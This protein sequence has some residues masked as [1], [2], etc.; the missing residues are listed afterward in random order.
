[1]EAF[2]RRPRKPFLGLAGA[3]CLGICVAEWIQPAVLLLLIAGVGAG[4][5]A[6]ARPRAVLCWVAV[7]ATFALLHTTRHLENAG[8]QFAARLSTPI[9]ADVEGVVWSEPA[10]FEGSRGMPGATFWL[11]L[12]R[13]DPAPELP[14][15]LCLARWQG[16]APAYGDRVRMRGA[17]EAL[18]RPRN[19]GQFDVGRW[20][21]RQGVHF[22]LAAQA[23]RDCEIAG[24][25]EGSKLRHV[26]VRARSWIQAQLDRGLPADPEVSALI[27]SMVLGLRGE[28]PAELKEL[29]QKT[30][31]LHLFAVSGLN[32]GMLAII[33][34]YALKPLGFGRRSGALIV[35]PLL[36]AYAVI[37]GMSASCMRATVVAAFLLAAPLWEREAVPVNSLAAAAVAILAWDTNEL[38]NP[39]FQLSFV[40]VAVI[41]AFSLRWQKS[42]QKI[43]EPDD[44]LPHRLWNPWQRSR[45]ALGRVVAGMAAV[46]VASWLGSVLFMWG[47]F[48]L[49][50]P[51][52]LAANFIAVP[53]AF[54]VLALG[55]LSLVCGVLPFAAPAV[56]VNHA[57]WLC[58]R[59]LI[60]CVELFAQVPRGHVYLEWPRFERAPVCEVVALD[61]GEGAAIHLRANGGDWLIDAGH[62][63]DYDRG[64]LPYLRARGIN[65]L[66]G[67]IL[68][69]GDGAHVGG[70]VSLLEDFTPR[71]IGET[72]ALDRSPTR[73]AFH[74]KLAAKQL[75]RR[76]FQ[77]G[78]TIPL[79]PE[80]RVRVL[81]PPAHLP[82]RDLADSKALV[83]QLEAAGAK[84]LFASDAGFAVEKWLL[85]ND[86]GLESDI[87]VKGWAEQDFSGTGD[88]VRRVAPRFV[89]C[90]A[91]KYGSR[92]E[93]FNAWA[94]PLRE[95][96]IAV[97]SQPESGA[98]RARLYPN[99]EVQVSTWLPVSPAR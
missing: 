79:G 9:T 29:F 5:F 92:P 33:A 35:I 41:L 69:H 88:F 98:V 32:V 68:T 65:Q 56:T 49:V 24:S 62:A 91:Q 38:F 66:D 78:D 18:D 25:G 43:A 93:E 51:I 47:Y 27:S 60:E 31:T 45:V 72:P 75:G 17:V 13:F 89:V 86:A 7:A 85:E 76:Y 52:A 80:A 12:S 94:Q 36:A 2:A 74:A 77:R 96:G 50:A 23:S 22:A 39:G 20:L 44:F 6:L 57:N 73:R 10:I 34:W 58:A 67:L 42:W 48:Q 54:G 61:A 82:P 87:L 8:R 14:G 1:M 11:K 70:A 55:L 15:A 46:G 40:L 3:A 4:G 95:R 99:G 37:A 59:L 53:I 30:G 84:V 71:W 28:T 90:A 81:Y 83:L 16:A 63:R 64:L 19:P 97:F 21:Q 26:A